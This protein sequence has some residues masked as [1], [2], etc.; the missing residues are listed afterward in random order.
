MTTALVIGHPITNEVAGSRVSSETSE[1]QVDSH[2]SESGIWNGKYSKL[3]LF[4]CVR[5]SRMAEIGIYLGREQGEM[6]FFASIPF[7]Y[8]LGG[9]IHFEL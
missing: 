2:T 5:E 1:M 6:F 4:F 7:P 3:I 9:E 8:T